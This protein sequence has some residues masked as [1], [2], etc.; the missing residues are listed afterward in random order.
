MALAGSYDIAPD[1]SITFTDTLSLDDYPALKAAHHDGVLI[2]T[3]EPSA[4][5]PPAA[6]FHS[7]CPGYRSS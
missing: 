3:S 2:G 4:S 1:Q 5:T 7:P 6:P